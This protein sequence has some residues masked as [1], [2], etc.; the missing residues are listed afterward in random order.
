MALDLHHLERLV[1]DGALLGLRERVEHALIDKRRE[2]QILRHGTSRRRNRRIPPPALH[3]HIA[4]P[5]QHEGDRVALLVDHLRLLSLLTSPGL[6]ALLTA[7]EAAAVVP[8]HLRLRAL[9]A[10]VPLLKAIR[11]GNVVAGAGRATIISSLRSSSG[12]SRRS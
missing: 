10:V 5:V 2:R 12:V 8:A 9:G 4:L 6:M 1:L 3:G 7:V 11:T